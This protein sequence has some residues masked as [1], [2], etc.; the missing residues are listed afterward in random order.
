MQYILIQEKQSDTAALLKYLQTNLDPAILAKAVLVN[1]AV[2]L[3]VPEA[4]RIV[5][6]IEF[7]NDAQLKTTNTAISQ[8]GLKGFTLKPS[9]LEF[10]VPSTL[11][12]DVAPSLGLEAS[13]IDSIYKRVGSTASKLADIF[14][15]KAS[16][17]DW[18]EL[19]Y[20][21]KDKT[22]YDYIVTA[23]DHKEP[24]KDQGR[25]ISEAKLSGVDPDPS[26]DSDT[27]AAFTGVKK[28]LETELSYFRF[29]R[30]WYGDTGHVRGFMKD[31]MFLNYSFVDTVNE[32]YLD[33]K[34]DQALVLNL[35]SLLGLVT[36]AVG[37]QSEMIATMIDSVF[38]VAKEHMQFPPVNTT[39]AKIKTELSSSYAKLLDQTEAGYARVL[40]D[41]GKLQAFG[42]MVDKEELVWPTIAKPMRVAASIAYHTYAL[43]QLLRFT[44]WRNIIAE[45]S[46]AS[47]KDK[48][49]FNPASGDY[50]LYS[51]PKDQGGCKGVWRNI[52]YLGRMESTGKQLMPVDAPKKLQAKLFGVNQSDAADP[53][54]K[55]PA[56]F[57]TQPKSAIRSGWD[58]KQKSYIP[59]L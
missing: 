33:L 27:L 14:S 39:I 49:K 40:G 20:K 54:L 31:Q 24:Y 51:S 50:K 9:P 30:D 19:G 29:L 21:D 15:S 35:E 57:Y 16:G 48:R 45:A 2:N 26:W 46:N 10:E 18:D 59:H 28:H 17:K 5:A 34:R 41:W 53:Q 32:N 55:L 13:A 52:F 36:K 47:M 38:K 3:G 25:T 8:S 6:G 22:V 58:L 23:L 56:S 43:S 11:N 7:D 42:T 44:D 4:I 1:E 37:T 12:F